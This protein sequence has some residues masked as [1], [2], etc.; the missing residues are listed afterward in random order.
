MRS[1]M[2]CSRLFLLVGCLGQ[3]LC[4]DMKGT[5]DLRLDFLTLWDCFAHYCWRMMLELDRRWVYRW[6]LIMHSKTGLW[7]SYYVIEAVFGCTCR[8]RAVDDTRV[9]ST[10]FNGEVAIPTPCSTSARWMVLYRLCVSGSS[11]RSEPKDRSMDS[12]EPAVDKAG[13]CCLED[14]VVE[15]T[16]SFCSLANSRL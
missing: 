5:E 13:R 8:G 4:D 2:D 6:R 9:I 3:S 1:I 10:L 16:C 11:D 15:S 14:T 7:R 12:W